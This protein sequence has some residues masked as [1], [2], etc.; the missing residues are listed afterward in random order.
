[1]EKK[2]AWTSSLELVTELT[3]GEEANGHG[4]FVQHMYVFCGVA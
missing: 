1:M 4:S 2:R 3:G